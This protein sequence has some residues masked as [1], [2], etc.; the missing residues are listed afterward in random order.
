MQRSTHLTHYFT[1]IELE[2]KNSIRNK[3]YYEFYSEVMKIA[4]QKLDGKKAKECN[5][6]LTQCSLTSASKTSSP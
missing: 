1:S 4:K 6:T 5:S 2:A 3:K